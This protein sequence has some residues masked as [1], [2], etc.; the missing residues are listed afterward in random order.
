MEQISN[1]LQEIN[2]SYFQET[3]P[4][5]W[6]LINFLEWR[7]ENLVLNDCNQEHGAFKSLLQKIIANDK[8]NIHRQKAQELLN[9]WQDIKRSPEVVK[10]WDDRNTQNLREKIQ[11]VK[12]HNELKLYQIESEDLNYALDRSKNMSFA[13]IEDR[14]KSVMEKALSDDDFMPVRIPKR[15]KQLSLSKKVRISIR[16][17]VAMN[18]MQPFFNDLLHLQYKESVGSASSKKAKTTKDMS[19]S[20]SSSQG[21][22][23][24]S[25]TP[26]VPIPS[27]SQGA[28]NASSSLG[29]PKPFSSSLES[30]GSSAEMTINEINSPEYDRPHT[31]PHQIRS[32]SKNQDLLKQLRQE[33]QRTKS[34]YEPICS[35]IIDTTNKLLMDRL[36]IKRD[37]TWDSVTNE[38]TEYIDELID[39]SDTRDKLRTKLQLP[40]VPPDEPYSFDKHYEMN[41]VHCF[42]NKLLSFF[43][44]SRNPLLDKNSEGWLNC[45]IL[46][47]LIDDCFLMCEEIQVHR[48]EEMSLASI[49]R[50]NLSREESEKKQSGHKID[51]L[52]RIDNMEY[53]GSETYTDEDSRNSKPISYKQKLF[54]EMKDQL[55]RLLKSLKFTEESIK[56]VKNIV[57]HGITHGGLNGKMYAMYY[58]ADIGYYFVFKTCQYRIGTTW[59]SIPESL[60]ALKDVLCLKNDITNV[61][62]IVKKV[63]RVALR[64]RSQDL[65]TID[66]LPETTPTPK[67][68]QKE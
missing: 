9:N 11:Y 66:N 21:L 38:A 33:K 45:H 44:A 41:W 18:F 58:D 34:T 30:A 22:P 24:P 68:S 13:A 48:G 10:F 46:S 17:Y 16:S 32:T 57:L 27:P 31:P 29:V 1:N 62:G 5:R 65:F 47:L 35:N 12:T 15:K 20:S 54:R 60:V 4:L 26:E 19:S 36:K 63:K 40:F 6:S 67:K 25:S 8:D 53:F 14:R 2:N 23:R 3:D 7:S 56:G 39:N 37:Y 51:I 50:K 42:A 43:E 28:P 59:G 61:L 49:E 55:D 52:F 64:T